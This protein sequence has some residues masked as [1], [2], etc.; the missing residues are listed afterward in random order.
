M[1]VALADDSALFRNG[2]DLLLRASGVEVTSQASSGDELMTNIVP[3]PPDA[4]VLDLR[5][6]PT[7][8]GEGIETAAAIRARDP[9]IGILVLSTYAEA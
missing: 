3:D 6:P 5:M 7:Y 8:T 2:L 9:G 1:R 4:V